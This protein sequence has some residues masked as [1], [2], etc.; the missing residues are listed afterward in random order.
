MKKI[1]LLAASAAMLL[2]TATPAMAHTIS[3]DDTDNSINNSFNSSLSVQSQSQ[4]STVSVTQVNTAVSGGAVATGDGSFAA[5][6]AFVFAP[7]SVYQ[8]AIQAGGDVY[9]HY[10]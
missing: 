5:S 7:V 2:A 10:Y 3:D 1:A 4:S 6:G 8:G 9:L